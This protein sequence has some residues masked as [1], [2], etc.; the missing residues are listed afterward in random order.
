[1]TVA[2]IR[3]VA[4]VGAGLFGLL[5]LWETKDTV[6]GLFGLHVIGAAEHGVVA[7]VALTATG[8][9]YAGYREARKRLP[10]ARHRT[11]RP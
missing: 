1:M 10:G 9:S 3:T 6:S 5:T 7:V 8:L 2:R 11:L 4:G